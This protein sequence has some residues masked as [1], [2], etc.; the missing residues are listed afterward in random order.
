MD[1]WLP[2]TGFWGSSDYRLHKWN[3]WKQH[4]Q[5]WLCNGNYF[6]CFLMLFFISWLLLSDMEF[7]FEADE[8]W[9]IALRW[10]EW[11]TQVQ[12]H[13]QLM[14]LGTLYRKPCNSNH[15][16][17]ITYSISMGQRALLHAW[18]KPKS[19]NTHLPAFSLSSQSLSFWFIHLALSFDF[20]S[21]GH[22]YSAYI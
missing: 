2:G 1:P 11:R 21:L 18:L 10:K 5:H 6:E 14:V 3:L 8:A 13:S 22:D 15:S 16:G 4:W 7:V 12:I 20:H 9:L 17:E 19:P